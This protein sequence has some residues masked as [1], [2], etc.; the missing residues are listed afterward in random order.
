MATDPPGPG[1]GFVGVGSDEAFAV[2]VAATA[3]ART[4]PTTAKVMFSLSVML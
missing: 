2:G 4:L 1:T 3:I